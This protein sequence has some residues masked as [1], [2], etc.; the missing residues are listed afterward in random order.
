MMGMSSFVLGPVT[1]MAPIALLG[2]LVLPIIWWILRVKPPQPKKAE[3]PPLQILAD[4]MTEEETPDSTPLWLLLFRLLLAAIIA[5]ALARPILG[6]AANESDR[7][8]ALIIDDGWAAASNWSV[9]LKDAESR[10]AKARRAN[11]NVLLLTTTQ[12]SSDTV[13]GP[14]QA[15]L[16]KIKAL[17][18]KALQPDRSAAATVLRG[19]DISDAGAIWMSSGLDF[20]AASELGAEIAKA[21]RARRLEPLPATLPILPGDISETGNG[22]R[23]IWHNPS[24]TARTLSITAHD[25]S[26]SVITRGEVTFIPGKT[27]TEAEFELPAD[28]R[29]RVSTVRAAGL[30]SA[31]TVKLLDD[32]WG[33]PLVGVLT[34]GKDT[35]SPLLSEPYYAQTALTPYADIFTGTLDTLLPLAPSII[36]MPDEARIDDPELVEYVETGGLLI[37]FAGP[38]LARRADSLLPVLIRQGD[39]ALGGALTW[40]D[41]QS[42]AEFSQDSPFYGLSAPDDILVRQQIM[43]EPGAQTD[44]ATWA[45]L[46]DGSPV[47]T[48]SV[49]G[50]GRIVLFHVTAG[51]EWSNLPVGGLYVD[52]LRRILP[53]AN[54]TPAPEQATIGDWAP[55]RILSGYGRLIAPSIQA[56]ALADDIF[57]KTPISEVHPAGLYKQGARRRARNMVDDPAAIKPIGNIPGVTPAQFETATERTLGGVLLSAALI[58]LSF[59]VIFSLLASGRMGYLVPKFSAAQKS[60]ALGLAMTCS[61]FMTTDSFAQD[62]QPAA[63]PDALGLH[64]AYVKTGNGRVDELSR[65]ALTS[66]SDA[67]TRRTTIEPKGVRGVTPGEDALVFYPFLYYP[68][69]RDMGVLSDEASAALNAYMAGGGTIVFDTRDQGDR[70]LTGNLVHPGLAA[71]TASLDI[72]QI[73]PTPEDHVLTKSFY[74]LQN[75]PGRWANGTVWVDKDRNGTARDGVSSVIIGANDWAAGWALAEDGQGLITLEKDMPRQREMSMRFGVNLAMYALA[76]NYKSD[77]VHAAALVERLGQQRRLP[78]DLGAPDS[79]DK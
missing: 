8:L 43:A 68:L 16:D 54:A 38:K 59:D 14:A 20:G 52:M 6:G 65:N 46:E 35:S 31:G 24:A 26:G 56:S 23:T 51:P 76:G 71:V 18:P 49:K 69:E 39:R 73:G 28:L 9:T 37:R 67:L 78:Q 13:F 45:R 19:I 7:P 50:L 60:A 33:R 63:L 40:E 32:S 21:A 79:G 41:P 15:A 4:V 53:L 55:D 42:L 47:V 22:F 62:S 3:F 1:F 27:T 29:N 74:L 25:R 58:M 34:T 36:I 30:P 66:L 77:Q 17:S 70:A 11:Q 5:I 48:S 64:L 10:I 44:A 2:L 61:I 75:F 12:P 72:P 57:A